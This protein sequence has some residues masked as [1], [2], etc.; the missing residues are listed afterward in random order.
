VQVGMNARSGKQFG[1][2]QNKWWSRRMNV[3]M[4]LEGIK[5]NDF[6]ISE[7]V[8]DVRAVINDVAVVESIALAERN[9]LAVRE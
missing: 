8:I 5:A 6:E 4:V 9:D 1:N 2:N 3:I 7:M